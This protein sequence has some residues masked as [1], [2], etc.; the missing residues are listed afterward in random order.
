MPGAFGFSSWYAITVRGFFNASICSCESGIALRANLNGTKWKRKRQ[1]TL[2]QET[3][4]KKP[5][6]RDVVSPLLFN[7]GLEHANRKWKF[8][9]QQC[10]LHCGDDELLTNVR[11]AAD[12]ML[13]A[14]SYTDLAIMAL[15]W[16]AWLRN[17]QLLVYIW[18]LLR[19]KFWQLKIWTN[20]CSLILVVIWLKYYMDK[21]KNI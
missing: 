1:E 7:A 17:W 3:L 11:Y 14:R 18:T 13:Y 12:L 21:I 10:G 8:R 2:E 19:P 15:W 5:W 20:Q 9:V 4:S 6:A 16:S